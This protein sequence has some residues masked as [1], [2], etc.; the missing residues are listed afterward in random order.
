[1]LCGVASS[2]G[3]FGK[4]YL[5]LTAREFIYTHG[6]RHQDRN[7]CSFCSRTNYRVA[8]L[9]Y[10]YSHAKEWHNKFFFFSDTGWE[11]P[12]WALWASFLMTI[13]LA[14]HFQTWRKLACS[15]FIL[16]LN[17]ILRL[18]GPTFFSPEQILINFCYKKIS[19]VPHRQQRHT[20]FHLTRKGRNLA[21]IANR[22]ML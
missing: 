21:K 12:I 20:L 1:M 3:P 6:V 10:R 9:K 19:S 8:L 15:W 11:F 17:K 4:E 5:D 7:Q 16:G 2:S 18:F 13:N 14:W 22:F